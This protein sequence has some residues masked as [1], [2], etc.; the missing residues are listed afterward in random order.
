MEHYLHD[1]CLQ[2]LVQQIVHA[3]RPDKIY[4]VAAAQLQ[5]H[6]CS[7]FTEQ[8]VVSAYANSYL[9]LVLIEQKEGPNIHAI[10]DKIEHLSAA[11]TPVITWVMTSA[12]FAA[13]LEAG[14][15]FASK[16][17]QAAPLC[18]TSNS[19][20]FTAPVQSQPITAVQE[21]A[22]VF[23]N[24]ANELLAGVELYLIRKQHALA[25]LLLHQSAEQLFTAIIYRST[26]YRPQTHNLE[27]LYQYARFLCQPL[28]DAWPLHTLACKEQLRHLNKAYIDT[29]Y[30]NYSI[31][32]TELRSIAGRLHQLQPLVA[33]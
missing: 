20:C 23:A 31:R 8:P 26:G 24:R 28:A 13:H 10:Q 7:I 18:Y 3:A 25:A 15:F 30:G 12:T 11:H 33:A 29:R 32:E 21:K 22:L 27:R 17:N 16:V 6:D 19:C 4:L 9:W 2:Q 14:D 1:A 5:Q